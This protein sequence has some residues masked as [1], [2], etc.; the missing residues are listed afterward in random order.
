MRYAELVKRLKHVK[1][2][3]VICS[4]KTDLEHHMKE[5]E[6]WFSSK[7]L[8]GEFN[9]RTGHHGVVIS[10]KGYR[11]RLTVVKRKW[12]IIDG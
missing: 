2:L 4:E 6:I 1:Q 7:E 12:S 10:R 11:K 9:K 8:S 5:P 3:K